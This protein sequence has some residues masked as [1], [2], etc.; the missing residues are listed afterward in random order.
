ML[1]F[2]FFFRILCI[3]FLYLRISHF[4]LMFCFFINSITF[5]FLSLIDFLLYRISYFFLYASLN[6]GWAFDVWP[7][8]P[9]DFSKVRGHPGNLHLNKFTFVLASGTFKMFFGFLILNIYLSNIFL[10]L[11]IING[12]I[13]DTF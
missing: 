8:R 10:A 5:L 4:S 11:L 12:F 7:P 9:H 6:N 13:K 1:C 2:F 3:S